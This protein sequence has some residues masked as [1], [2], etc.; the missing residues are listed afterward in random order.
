MVATVRHERAQHARIQFSLRGRRCPAPLIY[1]RAAHLLQQR[2][3]ASPFC[4]RLLSFAWCSGLLG[5]KRSHRLL[6]AVSMLAPG[7]GAYQ[8]I[9]RVLVCSLCGAEHEVLRFYMIVAAVGWPSSSDGA[10]TAQSFV[11][12]FIVI[13]GMG[14][15]LTYLGVMRYATVQFETYANLEAV[16]RSRLDQTQGES[17]FAPDIDVSTTEGALS[18]IPMGLLYLLFAPFPW[19]LASLRQSITL[20][21][22]LIWWAS[23]PLLVLG[24]WFTIKF[25]LRQ[26]MPILI[27]T[28]MLTLVYSVFQGNIGTAYRQRAQLLIFYFMFVAVGFVLMQEKREDKK[29]RELAE[30]EAAKE[31]A[32]A[33]VLARPSS[34]N[35]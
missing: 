26:A 16:Q 15:A 3:R 33:A 22:M 34:S 8:R 1:R 13:V 30:K 32:G 7:L 11:R 24:C 35:I 12:Q 25:R 31:A 17:G 28:P 6:L 21:E 29:R 4:R 5:L 19:Q 10:V 20:P 23:F 9:I 27:F 2:W 18:A 14:L